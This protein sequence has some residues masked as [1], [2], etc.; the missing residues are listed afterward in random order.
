MDTQTQVKKD[1]CEVVALPPDPRVRKL[2]LLQL[3]ILEIGFRLKKAREAVNHFCQLLIDRFDG[4]YC[5]LKGS[6]T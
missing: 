2:K 3:F 4:L 5:L 6:R 1:Q